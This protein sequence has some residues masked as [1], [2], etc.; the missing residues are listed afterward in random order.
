MGQFM[1]RSILIGTKG[2]NIRHADAFQLFV[3]GDEK[4]DYLY[5]DFYNKKVKFSD[6]KG[7]L[8]EADFSPEVPHMVVRGQSENTYGLVVKAFESFARAFREGYERDKRWYQ[9]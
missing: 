9:L 4:T 8:I 7:A 5:V 2:E 3:I 1:S 6:E